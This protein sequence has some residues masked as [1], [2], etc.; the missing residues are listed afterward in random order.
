MFNPFLEV[1]QDR[2]DALETCSVTYLGE[3]FPFAIFLKDLR[4]HYIGRPL[5]P[6]PGPS[7]SHEK[8][9]P[10]S[11]GHLHLPSLGSEKFA[12]LEAKGAFHTPV[13]D[14]LEALLDVFLENIYPT[15]PI[16]NRRDFIKWHNSGKPPWII[17]HA[18]FSV[19][20][21]YCR[22]HIL[23]RAGFDNRTQARWHCYSKAKALFDTG[24]ET[25]KVVLL[26]VV[27]LLSFWGG[28]PDDNWNFYSWIGMGVTIAETIGCH[29]SMPGTYLAP[30]DRRFLKR[31]WYVLVIRDAF[32]AALIGRQFKDHLNYCD[33][34][35]LKAKDFEL[36][37]DLLADLV[38]QQR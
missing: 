25:N 35:V 36:N 27:I 38:M 28:N 33:V 9:G 13:P 16:F 10:S 37:L 5:P 21:T 4:R 32:S 7:S 20:A 2:Y 3:L 24:Y 8:Q 11:P 31:L 12:F 1:R 6:L 14:T 34:N 22:P 26:Q 15:Y 30:H 23:Y 19:A 18:V 17:L 29:R